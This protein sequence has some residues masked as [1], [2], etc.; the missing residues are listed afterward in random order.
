V[1]VDAEGLVVRAF[2]GNMCAGV[3]RV[4]KWTLVRRGVAISFALVTRETYKYRLKFS[5]FCT[6]QSALK[7]SEIEVIRGYPLYIIR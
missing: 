7:S 3:R 5:G 1:A 2:S 4:T 6:L